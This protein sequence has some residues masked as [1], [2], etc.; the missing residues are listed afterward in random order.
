MRPARVTFQSAEAMV[1]TS[2]G[3][4]WSMTASSIE[5]LLA[6]P[7]VEGCTAWWL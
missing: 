1:S 4:G 6:T 3:P 2:S 5:L 7:K